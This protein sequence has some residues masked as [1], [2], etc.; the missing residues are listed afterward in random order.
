MDLWT[1]GTQDLMFVL[2]TLQTGSHKLFVLPWC[3]Y[4]DL[5]CDWDTG[6]YACGS[7]SDRGNES[8]RRQAGKIPHPKQI[9]LHATHISFIPWT[10]H[11]H[12]HPQAENPSIRH[13]GNTSSKNG[14]P[15]ALWRR[16]MCSTSC[17]SSKSLLLLDILT[18]WL[19]SPCWIWLGAQNVIRHF[20]RVIS[21]RPSLAQIRTISANSWYWK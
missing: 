15:I 6:P 21:S 2:K 16:A 1:L 3:M 20:V 18:T 7:I 10:P 19:T 13:T 14:V 8:E 5:R 17:L 12:S 11:P 9:P 4:V